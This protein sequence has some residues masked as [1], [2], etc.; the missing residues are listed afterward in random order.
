MNE[1]ITVQRIVFEYATLIDI[2]VVGTL[3]ESHIPE[4][5]HVAIRVDATPA[6]LSAELS[7]G[8][9]GRRSLMRLGERNRPR[10]IP[11][12]HD[13]R[14]RLGLRFYTVSDWR[15]TNGTGHTR[16]LAVWNGR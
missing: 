7:V 14:S 2:A 13:D 16:T 5:R 15:V 3:V 10:I 4:Q 12:V 8:A 9:D 1:T 11:R 6:L